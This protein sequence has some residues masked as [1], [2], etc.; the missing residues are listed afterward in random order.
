M[1]VNK[2]C[3]DSDSE[4]P[5]CQRVMIN[6]S[7]GDQVILS[8][9][10]TVQISHHYFETRINIHINGDK[11]YSTQ[12]PGDDGFASI[13]AAIEAART[14]FDAKGLSKDLKYG[15]AGQLGSYSHGIP[16]YKTSDMSDYTELEAYKKILR[17]ERQK[18]QND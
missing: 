7:N 9:S 5:I 4:K 10:P 12:A 18:H 14:Y 8:M 2:L 11:V 16:Y 13:L 3:Q 6:K 15:E 1:S 17:K